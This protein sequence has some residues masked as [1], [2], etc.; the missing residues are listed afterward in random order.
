MGWAGCPGSFRKSQEPY[1][2]RAACETT[3][4]W[5]GIWTSVGSWMRPSIR[6]RSN[7]TY[8]PAI[9]AGS[10]SKRVSGRRKFGEALRPLSGTP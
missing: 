8:S 4:R 9:L 3:R 10:N 1:L 6:S 5:K 2:E 7:P